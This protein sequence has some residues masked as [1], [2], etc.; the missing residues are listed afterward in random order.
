MVEEKDY[1]AVDMEFPIVWRSIG[2]MTGYEKSS[3]MSGVGEM[4][5][6]LMNR[7]LSGNWEQK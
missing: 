7:V 1:S 2:R 5:N 3:K 6:S 4:Y